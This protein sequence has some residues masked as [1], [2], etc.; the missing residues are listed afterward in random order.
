M[1]E[2]N[3]TD[4]DLSFNETF[5]WIFSGLNVNISQCSL[6]SVYITVQSKRWPNDTEL[7]QKTAVV[8]IHN[9]TFGSLY[10]EPGTKAQI[11]RCYIDGEFKVRA[12]LII[13]SNSDV[14]IQN[15]HFINFINENDSTILFGQNNSQVT[16]ENSVFTKHNSSKG[17]L[18]L[19]NNSSMQISTSLISQNVAFTLWYSSITLYNGIHAFV[20]NTT[21]TNNTALA[22][23]VMNALEQCKITLDNCSFS[24][25]KAIAVKSLNITKDPNIEITDKYGKF[26][27]WSL[28]SFNQTLL[29][30]QKSKSIQGK[31][32][33]ISKSLT[34]HHLDQNNI[35]TFAHIIPTLINQTSLRLQAPEVIPAERM[36]SSRK[37]TVRPR[38]QN[39]TGT[40]MLIVPILLYQASS[41]A[42]EPETRA[43]DQTN[44]LIN[45][46][47]LGNTVWLEDLP[48]GLEEPFM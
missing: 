13:A 5:R 12:T 36:K 9:S 40:S 27:S 45:S 35:R 30:H 8:M 31:K 25:N 26:T 6:D 15:C 29:L 10:L 1:I 22:G 43:D 2:F 28:N 17:V 7:F 21:F 24:S 23:G 32:L 48:T 47:T 44:R 38:D 20:K 33:N 16:I 34:G 4:V 39:N 37:S 3:I 18:F 42:K 41:N 14:S 11:T 19:Q 46:S